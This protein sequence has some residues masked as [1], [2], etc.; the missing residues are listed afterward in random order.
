MG[1]SNSVG[2]LRKAVNIPILLVLGIVY[3][4]GLSLQTVWQCVQEGAKN[5]TGARSQGTE[6]IEARNSSWTSQDD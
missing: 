4:I 3:V 2:R 1:M 5:S 6:S